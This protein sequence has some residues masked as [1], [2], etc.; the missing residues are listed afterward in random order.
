[1]CGI[2][3]PYKYMRQMLEMFLWSS[4]SAGKHNNTTALAGSCHLFP[5]HHI[6]RQVFSMQ[7]SLN[8]PKNPANNILILSPCYKQGREVQRGEVVCLMSHRIHHFK[9]GVSGW[10]GQSPNHDS[11]WRQGCPT[12]GAHKERYPLFG[13]QEQSW[14]TASRL[15]PTFFPSHTSSLLSS[16][17]CFILSLLLD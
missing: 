17:L 8:S 9:K 14:S 2:E 10:A 5:I 15:S 12:E 4:S 3:A 13:Y 7:T 11:M 16:V 6:L 1:M